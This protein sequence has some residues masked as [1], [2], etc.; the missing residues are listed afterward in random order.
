MTSFQSSPSV[1]PLGD[2]YFQFIKI[3]RQFDPF[4]LR[5]SFGLSLP[6]EGPLA[7][8]RCTLL[9]IFVRA[10]A[11]S[12]FSGYSRWEGAS[13]HTSPCALDPPIPPHL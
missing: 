11:H 3:P 9:S 1:K 6:Q 5:L 7:S 10:G 2:I 13:F 4:Y 8:G 12:F